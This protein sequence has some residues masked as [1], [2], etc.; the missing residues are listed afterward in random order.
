MKRIAL[1][2]CLV[3]TGC[4]TIPLPPTGPDAGKYGY[5]TVGYVPNAFNT[6]NLNING[7]TK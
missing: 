2:L 5:V 7:L 6:P 3:L 1:L 4:V